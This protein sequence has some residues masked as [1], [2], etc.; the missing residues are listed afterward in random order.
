VH[1][2]SLLAPTLLSDIV[3]FSPAQLLVAAHGNYIGCVPD[4]ISRAE[5]RARLGTDP[6]ATTFLF[7]GQLRAY[8]GV[9]GLLDA[10]NS[11]AD[12]SPV[13]LIV[14]GMPGGGEA[15]RDLDAV[16]SRLARSPGVVSCLEFIP[17][18]EVQIY[19]RAADAVILP[20]HAVLTSGSAILALSFGKPV[21]APSLGLIPDLISDGAEGLLYDGDETCGL[22]RAMRHFLTLDAG[23]RMRMEAAAREKAEGLSW[24]KTGKALYMEAMAG[25]VGRAEILGPARLR[26]FV[27]RGA[28]AQSRAMLAVLHQ[29]D[30]EKTLRYVDSVISQQEVPADV[31]IVSSCKNPTDYVLLCEQMP[32]AT[33]VQAPPGTSREDALGLASAITEQG[34][35]QLVGLVTSDFASSPDD[36]LAGSMASAKQHPHLT[37]SVDLRK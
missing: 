4:Q 3:R 28:V 14:A 2:H 26:C 18:E 7:F 6:A 8:K 29:G 20:Y 11:L 31:I 13:R 9:G 16:R 24:E 19:F 17:D 15:C 12:D 27:R 33:V 34:G 10:F 22:L 21:I 37:M 25:A 5:A 35:C 32:S 30:V 23:T 36:V 1:V